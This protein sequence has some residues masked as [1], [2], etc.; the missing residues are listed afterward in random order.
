[1]KLLIIRHGQ[2]S[3]NLL[4]ETTGSFVGRSPDPV[5]TDLGQRQAARLAEAMRTGVQPAPAVLY[6]SLMVR[7]VQTAAVLA[8]ALDVPVAGHLE[9]YECGG[10]YE[11]SP[12]HPKPHPGSPAS[13]LHGIT[14][15]LNLPEGAGEQGWYRGDGED[16]AARARRGAR[17]IDDL[18]HRH[19]GQDVLVG[20]VCHEWISQHLIRAAIGFDA[21]GG[22]AEPWFSLNNT[23]TVL[24][25][26]E[27][28]VPVTEVAHNGGSV[29]RVLEWH[30]N[31]RHL[32]PDEISS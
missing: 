24:I 14:S 7:A 22:L 26:F 18:K 2:S 5:L 13:V 3:N 19:L 6:S 32:A 27:Q 29:E 1:M 23:G 12:L 21:P 20:L 28:P 11:G 15:R 16:D 10:P 4:Q 9:A 31:C 17:V 25:D 30:N 8:E